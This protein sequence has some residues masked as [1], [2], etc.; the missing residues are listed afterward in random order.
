MPHFSHSSNSSAPCRNEWRPSRLLAASLAM[1]GAL[2]AFSSLA[3]EAPAGVAWPVALA[4]AAVGALL[5]N[6]HLQQPRLQLVWS[7]GRGLEVDGHRVGDARLAWRGPL[8]FLD[9]LDHDGRRRRV[10]W[11]PDTLDA[12]GRRELRLA[13]M[14]AMPSL[15]APSMAP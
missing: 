2:G 7:P 3:S 14:A 12:A 6:R 1:L 9:W 13:A 4:S 10:S 5:A 8:A 15:D 11:W